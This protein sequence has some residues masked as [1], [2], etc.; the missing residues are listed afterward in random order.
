MRKHICWLCIILL[1]IVYSS[2]SK[3]QVWL[4]NAEDSLKKAPQ[5]D[6]YWQQKAFEHYWQQHTKAK[7]KGWKQFK[8]WEWFMMPRVY[9]DG[10]FYPLQAWQEQEKKQRQLKHLQTGGSKAYWSLV[11]PSLIPKYTGLGRLNTLAFHPGNSNIL[12]VGAPSGGFWKTTSGGNSWYTTTDHLASIGVSDIAIDPTNAQT[13]YIATGDGDAQDTYTVGVLKSVDGGENWSATGLGFNVDQQLSCRR[14]LINPQNTQIILVA[15]DAGIFR[16]DNA[17]N[18]W[19]QTQTGQFKDIE[20]KPDDPSVIYAAGYGDGKVFYSD[21][22]GESFAQA[23]MPY[24]RQRVHRIELAVTPANPSVVYALCTKMSDDGFFGLYK[25]TDGGQ[26]YQEVPQKKTINLLGWTDDG[27]DAG[28]QGWYDLA[29]AVSPL[30]EDEIYVGG[31]NVW[32]SADGGKS[33]TLDCYWNDDAGVPLVHADHHALVFSP[34]DYRLYSANDGGLYRREA[35]GDWTD[36]SQGLEILQIY[37]TGLSALPGLLMTGTQDNGTI[38]R[39][40]DKKWR[41]ITSGD[42]MSCFFDHHDTSLV[43]ASLYYGTL[44][45]SENGGYKFEDI[46]P[47]DEKEQGAWLTP[48]SPHPTLSDILYAAYSKVYKSSDRGNN[49]IAI[50]PEL[51]VSSSDKLRSVAIAPSNPQ[52]I[53]AATYSKIWKTTD[54]GQNWTAIDNGLPERAITQIAVSASEA[55]H[56]TLSFSGYKAG[57]KVYQ[58]Q[59]GGQSWE[60]ISYNLPNLPVNSVLY[61]PKSKQLLYVATD[62]GVYFYQVDSKLW[63]DYS[64]GLPNVVVNDLKIDTSQNILFAATYGRGLWQAPLSPMAGF[65]VNSQKVTINNPVIFTDSSHLYIDDYF[66]CFGEGAEP[67]TA[68]GAGPHEITYST[69]GTK[70]V[71]LKVSY[72]DASHTS[73]KTDYVSVYPENFLNIAPNPNKGDFQLTFYSNENS[74]LPYQMHDNA[75]RLIKKGVL[76]KSESI[77]TGNFYLPEL[78]SGSY[79]LTIFTADKLVREKII[80]QH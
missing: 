10:R 74:D 37:R 69:D 62:L 32:Q 60:N 44:Y 76:E 34:R 35:N 11:G 66:W 75:G 26:S 46:T 56:L 79:V 18:D 51:P 58:S 38:L 47:P 43:Y 3:A 1:I 19:Q 8:R 25:S 52:V 53:Y 22:G 55:D 70:T 7:G 14:L 54:G 4:F 5:S 78:E 2:P 23:N 40:S 63:A 64:L 24:I 50:S 16:S 13:I 36:L 42:G 61:H 48:F 57:E 77:W 39:T 6:F 9:P 31:I 73:I 21:D 20:F 15:C 12:Y 80:I 27:A 65:D 28:G 29:L 45:R 68:S 17:G 49:W 71:S 72:G 30:D 59:D 33:W 67:A 41:A